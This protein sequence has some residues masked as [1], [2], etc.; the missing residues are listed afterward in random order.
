MLLK[1]EIRLKWK[2]YIIMWEKLYY[3]VG[4][5]LWKINFLGKRGESQKKQYIG[6]LGQFADLREGNLAKESNAL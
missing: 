4:S 2:N 6:G 1:D 3:Y 5:L